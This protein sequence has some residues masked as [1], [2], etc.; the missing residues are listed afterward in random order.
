[1]PTKSGASGRFR[2]TRVGLPPHDFVITRVHGINPHPV[3][4]LERRSQKP[5]AI[6]H[7]WRRA[8][9]R[10][11]AR[12]E[13]FVDRRHLWFRPELH[14]TPLK[15]TWSVGSASPALR[16]RLPSAAIPAS[17]VEAERLLSIGAE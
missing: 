2:H 5:P 11:G 14:K 13:H 15:R 3:F 8:D 4:G 6:L 1:M 17:L 7:P 10:N 16:P 9:D 12:V